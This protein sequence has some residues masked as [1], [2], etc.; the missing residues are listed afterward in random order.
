MVVTSSR[1]LRRIS[2]TSHAAQPAPPISISSAGLGPAAGPWGP[3]SSRTSSGSPG[4]SNTTGTPLW[5]A[6]SKRAV[7]GRQASVI[8]FMC[9]GVSCL[10]R[11]ARR[12]PVSRRGGCHHAPDRDA[13]RRTGSSADGECNRMRGARRDRPFRRPNPAADSL[14][15]PRR[16]PAPATR[17]GDPRRRPAPATRAGWLLSGRTCR[18]LRSARPRPDPLLRIVARRLVCRPYRPASADERPAGSV[19]SAR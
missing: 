19:A 8:D 7:P 9:V 13:G 12:R 1:C 6:A 17:A 15:D 2:T 18:R 14:G 10:G 3:P 4:A 16:R 5:P 11:Y